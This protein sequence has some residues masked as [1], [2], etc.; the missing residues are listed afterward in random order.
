VSPVKHCYIYDFS[1][2]PPPS[3]HLTVLPA[4]VP[5]D[6]KLSDV[7]RLV[8][9][10]IY[11]KRSFTVEGVAPPDEAGASDLT[12]LFD[13]GTMTRAGAII[14]REPVRNKNGIVV[15]DPKDALYRL[16]EHLGKKKRTYAIAGS[17]V[18]DPSV[19]LPSRC[20]IEPFAV[21]RR[22]ARLGAG[23]RVGAHAY[24][25]EGVVLGKH[26]DLS[27]HVVIHE[28]ARIGD[29]VIIGAGSVL[30]KEGFGFVKKSRYR[31]LRHIGTV[32]VHDYVDIG[33]QVTIDRGTI[34]STVIGEGTKIDNLVHI[35]HN[36]RIGKD[37]IIMGQ[38][39][40]AGSA[41]LGDNVVLC[42]QA[43]VADH[44]CVGD[45]VVVY[46]KSAVFRTIP[47]NKKYSGIPARE[48]AAV[49]RALARL[50]RQ[51]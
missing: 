9:G 17:A 5:L 7:G 34:G 29:H 33:A 6:V 15:R 38:C 2:R 1:D 4:W 41:R 10:K 32:V 8:K 19:K 27:P 39:G 45:N 30:G 13:P 21:I 40:I 44:V 12:I 26:C 43:G 22:N 48:H 3:Q 35:A 47:P 16:L 49:L 20:E 28:N 18:I 14:A 31:R 46:A 42:G 25:G 23:S 11:G 36:V 51:R 50:Y 37:C 24:I